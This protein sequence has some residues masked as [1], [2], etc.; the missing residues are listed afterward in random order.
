MQKYFW[1]EKNA[2]K[3][4]GKY[5]VYSPTKEELERELILKLE[6]KLNRI[7][8]IFDKNARESYFQNDKKPKIDISNLTEVQIQRK[9]GERV[10]IDFIQI[11]RDLS[12]FYGFAWP[13]KQTFRIKSVDDIKTNIQ[14]DINHLKLKQNQQKAIRDIVVCA[15]TF[16]IL[17]ELD[18]EKIIKTSLEI[19]EKEGSFLKGKY[20]IK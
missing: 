3:F 15:L 16:A 12:N 10:I 5:E 7:D 6:Q 19:E 14:Q 9:I 17:L 1:R 2:D 20:V 13:D 8:V 11:A 4:L 18:I